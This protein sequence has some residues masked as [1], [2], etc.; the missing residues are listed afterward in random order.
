VLAPIASATTKARERALQWSR[1]RIGTL[2][3]HPPAPMRIP[4]RQ[5]RLTPPA[6]PPAIAIVTPSYNQGRFVERTLTSVLGQGYPALEYAVQDGGSTDETVAVLDAYRDRLTACVAEPDDG[7]GDAINRGFAN[8]D[9]EIMAWLNSDDLLLPGALAAVARHFQANPD[10]D[11]VYGHRLLIDEDDRQIGCWV[12]PPHADWP[13]ELVDLIPQETLFWRRRAWD[14]AGGRLDPSFRFALDWD[15]LLRLRDAGAR[16][17]RIPFVLG[18]FRIHAAQKTTAELPTGLVEVE[19]IR[20]TRHDRAPTHDEAWQMVHPYL[21]RHVIQHTVHR[22][23]MRI[24][25]LYV[26]I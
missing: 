21:R 24:P 4:R 8:V 1:P 12:M 13:L 2:R 10:V 11:V 14:A 7:Q 26:E 18:G 5:A 22:A 6:H 20:A 17:E 16:I 15:L 19:R 9:G 3:Q 23:A 25:G